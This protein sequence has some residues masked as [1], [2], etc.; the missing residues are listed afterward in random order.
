MT[1]R[2]SFVIAALVFAAGVAGIGAAGR[3]VAPA[4]PAAPVHLADA[5][6]AT[7]DRPQD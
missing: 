4:A 5:D 3:L 7:A 1:P 6:D 2:R